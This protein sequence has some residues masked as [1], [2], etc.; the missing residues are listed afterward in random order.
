MRDRVLWKH[1]SDGPKVLFKVCRKQQQRQESFLPFSVSEYLP[2][3]GSSSLCAESI[4]KIRA[5]SFSLRRYSSD[6]P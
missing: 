4:F 2:Q 3:A 5:A 6:D 1:P